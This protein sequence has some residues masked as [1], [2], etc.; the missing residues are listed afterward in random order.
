MHLDDSADVNR[1]R[2]ELYEAFCA[3]EGELENAR[4]TM[5]AS[6]LL[7]EASSSPLMALEALKRK[8]EELR[9][10]HGR[11]DLLAGSPHATDAASG[12]SAYQ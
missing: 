7:G 6:A 8:S 9:V 2:Q 4:R 3:L 1:I 10:R 12:E 11:T 5:R